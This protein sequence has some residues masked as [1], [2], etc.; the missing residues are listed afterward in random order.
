MLLLFIFIIFKIQRSRKKNSTVLAYSIKVFSF[1]ALLLNTI[2]AIPFFNT[3]LSGL[4]CF[5]DDQVHN[6][7]A[8]YSGIYFLHFV[9]SLIGIIIQLF[10]SILTSLLFI[11]LNPYST[12][13]FSAPQNK[14]N[15]IK[16]LIKFV[17]P[18]YILVDY[19]VFF[20]Q[21]SN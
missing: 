14:I 3:F 1:Y 8:C 10:F 15:L 19:Q 6:T 2:L 17:L 11:D 18:L 5:D 7:L 12:I 13:Q 9:I 20:F 21:K 4:I 16:L